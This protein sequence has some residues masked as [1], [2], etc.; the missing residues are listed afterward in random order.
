MVISTFPT[1]S[2]KE[3]NHTV[4]ALNKSL[5]PLIRYKGVLE[6][7]KKIWDHVLVPNNKGNIQILVD[8]KSACV[9]LH[10]VAKMCICIH[11]NDSWS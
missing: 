6:V 3:A 1:L 11:Y 10:G 8:S 9:W 5:A 2:T 7:F 4:F